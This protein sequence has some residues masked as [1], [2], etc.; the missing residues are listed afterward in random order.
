MWGT[1]EVGGDLPGVQGPV[2]PLCRMW[3]LSMA[4][5]GG[6]LA[7]N[8]CGVGLAK[9]SGQTER[10]LSELEQHLSNFNVHTD[11]MGIL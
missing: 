5:R 10:T 6:D 4:M 11:H 3:R 7:S 8:V 2:R 9:N 1:W